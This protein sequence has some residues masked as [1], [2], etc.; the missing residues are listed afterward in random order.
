MMYGDDVPS[1]AFRSSRLI[2]HGIAYGMQAE[3]D[4][5]GRASC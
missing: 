5:E 2:T 1:G 4:K 3:R